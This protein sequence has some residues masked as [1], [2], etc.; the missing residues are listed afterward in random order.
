MMVE[1]QGKVDKNTTP[2]WRYLATLWVLPV[3]SAACLFV[4]LH[5]VWQ[6]KYR[7]KPAE[8]IFVI[9]IIP[10]TLSGEENQDREPFLAID[11]RNPSVM[12]VS[13]LTPSP[14]EKDQTPLFF[15]VDN[16]EDWELADGVISGH[17]ENIDITQAFDGE[18]GVLF[19]G[20][21]RSER[22]A[23]VELVSTDFPTLQKIVLQPQRD[24]DDQPFL[25]ATS[26][27]SSNRVYVGN[28]DDNQRMKDGRTAT[29]D[30]SMDRGTTFVP[31]RLESRNSASLSGCEGGSQDG[32]SV[33][34]AV[35]NDGTV[36][37]AYFGWRNFE[38]NCTTADITADVVVAR[39]DHGGVGAAPFQDLMDSKD[40]KMGVRV[41]TGVKIPWSNKPTIGQE[42]IG[43]TLSLAVDPNNSSI[44]YIA[45]ADSNGKAE[46]AVHVR[47]SNDRGT[48]WSPDL[49]LL[50]E[51][52]N[53][54]LCIAQ[55][56]TL[57][58][59][60]QQHSGETNGKWET[61]LTQTQNGFVATEDTL[62]AVTP[63]DTPKAK[64]PPYLGDYIGLLAVKD[65]FR[66]V[67]SASNIPDP[68]HFPQGVKFQRFT[69][70]TKGTLT[71]GQDNDIAPSIDPFYFSVP[72]LH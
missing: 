70:R 48:S 49:L 29:I 58:V 68:T 31:I 38:G 18:R 37:V 32:P 30:V 8:K 40:G 66:G 41:A 23:L 13:A 15:S 24:N 64:H 72:L 39:D 20:S 60:F 1:K 10:A 47:R 2:K 14:S 63:S 25:V 43:S 46:Y 9:D 67:F 52:V 54:A 44:V 42:R 4:L 12:V 6:W 35:S 45:W 27:G 16:G 21:I 50:P 26:I 7:T 28:N 34:P 69:N 19:G 62:L 3:L 33:R 71:N 5:K 55:N 36:Y 22:N 56:G 61:H 57:G 65:E 51:T 11:Q 53:I 17:G 59:L